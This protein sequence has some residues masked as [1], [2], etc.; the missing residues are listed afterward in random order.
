MLRIGLIMTLHPSKGRAGA[1]GALQSTCRK[2]I[3]YGRKALW[4]VHA[5]SYGVP[6]FQTEDKMALL[7][8]DS[9]A[10]SAAKSAKSRIKTARTKLIL[11]S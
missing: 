7:D 5:N 1:S 6:G 11:T 2:S 9:R 10:E 3:P 4:G 8:D